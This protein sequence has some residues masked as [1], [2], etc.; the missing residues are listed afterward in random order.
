MDQNVCFLRRQRTT[1]SDRHWRLSEA[2]GGDVA[3]R[4][5]ID[6]LWRAVLDE[7]EHYVYAIP[8]GQT[9]AAGIDIVYP[10]TRSVEKSSRVRLRSRT[11]PN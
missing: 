1:L 11:C 5:A 3:E 8:L 4:R 9:P 10:R 2:V 7:D 6:G